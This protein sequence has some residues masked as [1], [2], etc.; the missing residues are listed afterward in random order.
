M[1]VLFNK[2]EFDKFVHV[3]SINAQKDLFFINFLK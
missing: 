3:E 2:D 1:K